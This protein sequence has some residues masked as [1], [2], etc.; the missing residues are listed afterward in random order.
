MGKRKY[1]G[2]EGLTGGWRPRCKEKKPRA[3]PKSRERTRPRA[4]CAQSGS[5]VISE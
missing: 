1:P 2:E 4:L 5:C 3:I